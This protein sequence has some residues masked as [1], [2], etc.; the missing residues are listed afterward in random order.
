MNIFNKLSFHGGIKP[1]GNKNISTKN[2][3]KKIF[4]PD[5]LI[6]PLRQS[7]GKAPKLIVSEGD[8]VLKGQQLAKPSSNLSVGI[9]AP[10][11][12]YIKRIAMHPVPHPSMLNEECI[13]LEPD[14]KDQWIKKK[15]IDYKNLKLE[16]VLEQL[17]QNGL[18]GMGGATFP[19]HIKAS[20]KIET[21]I[22]NAAECEPFI[23]C[24]DMALREKTEEFLTGVD[25]AMHILGA[26]KAIIGIE[27][28]KQEAITELQK[29]NQNS[30]IEIK[31]IP[32]VYPSGDEKR[33][34]FLVSGLKIKKM[35]R[36]S[37][38]GFQIFN[39]GTLISIARL[40]I[41]GE[42]VISRVV[43]F[44]GNLKQPNNFEALIGT[45][46]KYFLNDCGI[47]EGDHQ[48]IMGGPMMGFELQNSEIT[49]TKSMNCV[50]IKRNETQSK[51][52][53]IMP[54]IRCSRCVEVCPAELQP[55]ELYWFS[56][57]KQFEKTLDY[58]LF[59]CI[60]CGCCSYVCPSNIPLVSYYRY[61][62]SEIRSEEISGERADIARDR[63]EFRLF[64][65]DREKTERAERNAQRRAQIPDAEKK[66]LIEEKKAAIDMALKDKEEI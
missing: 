37:N 60:E 34:L 25:I 35:D 23:T 41:H 61:A 36:P 49:V 30:K 58:K 66:K 40:F 47:K 1:Q 21:L 57:S 7:V 26:K 20:S 19:T 3:I 29:K 28:N 2:P 6:L 38:H 12:G 59:D 14:H 4:I 62:K 52:T 39:V 44:T 31:I 5:M 53:S 27:D 64:R 11:S 15:V 45:P 50:L 22:V 51:D 63:N 42:P 24:D 43:T 8:Y 65:L 16:E 55:Q 9:H 18:V 48:I 13:F 46:I 17:R 56:K 54:C 10:T 33:L 32:T